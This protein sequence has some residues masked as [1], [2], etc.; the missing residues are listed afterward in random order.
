MHMFYQN[1]APFDRVP[2]TALM[3][4]PQDHILGTADL[5]LD[6]VSISMKMRMGVPS[7]APQALK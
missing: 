5:S 6:I 4:Q 1:D 2:A 7:S 3:P